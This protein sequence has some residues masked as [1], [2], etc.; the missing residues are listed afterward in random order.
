MVVLIRMITL[1]A[2]STIL[3][4]FYD[5]AKKALT[6]TLG[7][8]ALIDLVMVFGYCL[9]KPRILAVCYVLNLLSELALVILGIL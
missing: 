6:F 7:S 9:R 1:I 8:L 4:I 5:F 2:L 3:V